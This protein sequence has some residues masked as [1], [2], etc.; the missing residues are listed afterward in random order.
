[1]N[2]QESQSLLDRYARGQC[3]PE[4]SVYVERWYNHLASQQKVQVSHEELAMRETNLNAVIHNLENERP[5]RKLRH[6]YKYT[7][8]AAAITILTLSIWII[9][10]PKTGQENQQN[11]LLQNDIEPGKQGA[12]LTLANGKKIRLTQATNGALAE[13][14]GVVITKT[15]NGQLIYEIKNT[16]TSSNKKNTLSTAKGETYQLKLSD[17]TMVWLNAASSLTYSATLRER[18]KRTVR[19]TGEGYFQVAKDKVH[20]FIVQTD[21]QE[22]EVLGTHFNINSYKD[23]SVQTTTLIEGSVKVHANGESQIIKPGEQTLN[24]GNNIRIAKVDIEEVIDWKD[25]D[26]NLNELDF[27]TAM[28]KIARWYDVEVIYEK[29]APLNFQTVGWISRDKTLSVVL[30]SI[31]SLGYVHFKI[32]GKKIY[33]TK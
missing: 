6:Y 18:G 27:Q 26:F 23:E 24:D 31:E 5:I 8:I 10:S 29:N 7:A 3:S 28:R 19:L 22:V 9:F 12:T 30:N 21:Q 25:G 11:S 33:V 14:S 15:E 17:G 13:E 16:N 4:E 20:P 2:E 1:M 32:E